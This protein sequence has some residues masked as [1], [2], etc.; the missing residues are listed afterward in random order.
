MYTGGKFILVIADSAAEL[1]IISFLL[2]RDG[3]LV[4]T[5]A[6]NQVE[7]TTLEKNLPDLILID[8]NLEEIDKDEL[9]QYFNSISSAREIPII[10]INP[11]HHSDEARKALEA[12]CSDFL[13]KPINPTEL[14]IRVKTQLELN[15]IRKRLL[16]CGYG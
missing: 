5:V 9:Y 6:S 1:E 4:H 8:I 11:F 3:Y 12:G 15:A 16:I 14:S 13:I 10:C 7:F 2:K